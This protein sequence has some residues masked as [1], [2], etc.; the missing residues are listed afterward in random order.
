MTSQN[1]IKGRLF[2]LNLLKE[3]AFH[4]E[5][6]DNS[7]IQKID[8]ELKQIPREEKFPYK[9]FAKQ[10][11]DLCFENDIDC[12]INI[13]D[14]NIY[15]LEK[16]KESIIGDL[17]N[18]SIDI[19]KSTTGS[20]DILNKLIT[21]LK[22]Y[23]ETYKGY[24]LIKLEN[25]PTKDYELLFLYEENYYIDPLRK[26]VEST[27]GSSNFIQ[28]DTFH[29]NLTSY[30]KNYIC[31]LLLTSK[32]NNENALKNLKQKLNEIISPENFSLFDS[33]SIVFEKNNTFRIENSNVRKK[34]IREIE[35]V[36]STYTSNI[37]INF[38]EEKIIKTLCEPFK[39]PLIFYKLLSSGFSGAKV[40]EIRPKKANSFKN[41]KIYIIKFG[42][43]KDE[44]L[45]KEIDNYNTYINGFKG[46]NEYSATYSE[47]LT[48][49]GILYNFAISEGGLNSYSFCDILNDNCDGLQVNKKN[50][51]T[52]LFALGLFNHW[53][54]EFNNQTENSVKNSYSE[55]VNH[56]KIFKKLEEILNK[57]SEEIRSEKLFIN[58][59]KIWEYK[60]KFFNKVC[61]GD[62]HTENFFID[63]NK[64]IYLIDF[65][66]T[67]YR[68][69]MIDYSSL[70]C[71]LK[72]KHI[73]RYITIEE[74]V[75]IEEVLLHNGTFEQSYSFSNTRD[76]IQEILELIN[77]IRYCSTSDFLNPTLFEEY[78]ISLFMMTIRQIQ[79]KDMNQLYAYHSACLLGE[80]IVTDLGL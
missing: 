9:E 57:S 62:L 72:F 55:Y 25:D 30:D 68:H 2:S 49:E 24:F 63:N 52:D 22:D 34:F 58:F 66:Y 61:H 7:K 70:E 78:Y 20:I 21:N 44:K 29:H 67:N 15:S 65:G 37:K 71:S 54:A 12:N 59:Y 14:F 76:G 16:S 41:E 64:N 43:G 53:K 23:L 8:F 4:S 5:P 36:L 38:E 73:P 13:E 80:K 28:I 39:T 74:L 42:L 51:I 69:A 32:M 33:Y 77:N 56:D 79:Y 40:M 1:S 35:I 3:E 47:T 27:F 50:I 60:M 11:V 75:K 46:F 26:K 10:F 17:L 6:I 18:D 19:N 48:H 45:K 31:V